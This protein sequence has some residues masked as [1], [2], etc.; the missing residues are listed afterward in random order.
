VRETA[1]SDLLRQELANAGFPDGFDLTIGHTYTPGAL[2]IAKQFDRI[3]LITRLLLM[4]E[5]ELMAAFASGQLHLALIAWTTPES[6]QEWAAHFGEENVIDL[7][8]LPISY[9]ASPGLS[10]TFTVNGW[11]LAAR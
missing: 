10:I 11:P 4:D 8:A 2:Q 1:A 6:R 5:S 7:Y 9:L 3:G